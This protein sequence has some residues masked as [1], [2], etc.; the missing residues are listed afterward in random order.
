M[1][2]C[3]YVCVHACKYGAFTRITHARALCFVFVCECVYV[4]VCVLATHRFLRL[5]PTI[6]LEFLDEAA[7]VCPLPPTLSHLGPGG[8]EV[9]VKPFSSADAG[10]KSSKS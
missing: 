7:D 10:K 9:G 6:P 3:M 2:V 5:T 4:C 1:C 8:G